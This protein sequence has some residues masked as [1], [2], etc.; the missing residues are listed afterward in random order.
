MAWAVHQSISTFVNLLCELFLGEK[1]ADLLQPGR[2]QLGGTQVVSV[3]FTEQLNVIMAVVNCEI[4]CLLVQQ[5]LCKFAS[6]QVI[7]MGLCQALR[8]SER[9]HIGKSAQI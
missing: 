2:K 8:L 7:V 5:A 9:V 6:C 4:G 1:I 3:N